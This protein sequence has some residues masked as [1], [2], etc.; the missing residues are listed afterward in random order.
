MPQWMIVIEFLRRCSASSLATSFCRML[1]VCAVPF[2]SV[3]SA[4][5][6]QQPPA[7]TPSSE[8]GGYRRK[9]LEVTEEIHRKHWMPKVQRYSGKAG[10]QQPD[11]VWGAG[12]MFSALVG[13]VRHEPQ[14]FAPLL[15]KYFDGLEGYWDARA[16]VPAYEPTPTQNGH[17]K[18]Y[19]DNAWMVIT[20][21]EAYEVTH[22]HRYRKR[23][24]ETLDFVLSGWDEKFLD[25]GIW[26]H[27]AHEKKAQCKNTCANGPS[28]VACLLSAKHAP[29]AQAKSRIEW[30]RKITDWTASKL[31]LNDGLFADSIGFDGKMNRDK[32]TYN[33]AL[34]LRAYLGLYRV[35]KKPED[36]AQA[37][38]IGRAGEWFLGKETGA[39]RD[40]VKWAHLMVE[41]DLELY[42][43]TREDYLLKRAAK[44]ADYYYET[45]KRAPSDDLIDVAS[46]ARTLWLMADTE[47]EAGR[48]FWK[49]SDAGEIR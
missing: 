22:K 46:I 16:K 23:A 47:T 48:Q 35:T 40:A 13:A 20:F 49:A 18:Y 38:R 45:W 27:E 17:D 21:L 41:A 39:Y 9:A 6:Q 42:R 8:P 36:L 2:A 30:A 11:A 15:N 1:L 24:E 10:G 14:K 4:F 12:V 19:D 34:M 29:A 32:L 31:Q 37:Q 26:W 7:E 43:T 3:P 5:S 25:G 28:A 33:S 44:N